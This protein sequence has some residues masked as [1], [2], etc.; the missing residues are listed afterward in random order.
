MASK[1]K[2][3]KKT[4]TLKIKV[5]RADGLIYACDGEFYPNVA[6]AIVMF[7]YGYG[8]ERGKHATPVKKMSKDARRFDAAARVF[9]KEAQIFSDVLK[10]E[11]KT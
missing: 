9:L 4:D 1:K 6:F 10:E 7:T 3:I 8:Q 11:E 2:E 5:R